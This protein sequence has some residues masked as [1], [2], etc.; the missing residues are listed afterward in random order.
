VQGRNYLPLRVLSK[1]RVQIAA[2]WVD[3]QKKICTM[4]RL[5]PGDRLIMKW[6]EVDKFIAGFEG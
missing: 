1:N 4:L 5:L 2:V 3:E 6:V